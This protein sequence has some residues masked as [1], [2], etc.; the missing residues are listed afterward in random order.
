MPFK[1]GFKGLRAVQI[2][3]DDFVGEVAMLVWIAAQ[4]AHLELA[5]GLQGTDHCASLLPRCADHGDH[6]FN[7]G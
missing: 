4:S 5:A 2:C 7:V 6:L 1:C 3:F